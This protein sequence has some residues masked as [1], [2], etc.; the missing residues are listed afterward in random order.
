MCTLVRIQ[1]WLVWVVTL[2]VK[3]AALFVCLGG[4][5]PA[6]QRRGIHC[7]TASAENNSETQNPPQSSTVFFFSMFFLQEP[8]STMYRLG[9]F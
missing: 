1:E 7:A 4:L 6:R 9:L 2:G 8:S 3:V 5:G